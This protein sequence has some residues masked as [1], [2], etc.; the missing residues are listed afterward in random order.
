MDWYN[1]SRDCD[2]TK[3]GMWNKTN[4]THPDE[5]GCTNSSKD[6]VCW[7]QNIQ[8][9]AGGLWYSTLQEGMCAPGSSTGTCSWKV[10]S[11]STVNAS[12]VKSALADAVEQA[13]SAACFSKLGE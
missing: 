12:C 3:V 1:K 2:P 8:S 4:D 11:T 13:D 6:Y 5:H 10:T 9:K 7:Q